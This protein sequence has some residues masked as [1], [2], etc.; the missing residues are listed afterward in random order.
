MQSK[1]LMS[2][3]MNSLDLSCV[4]SVFVNVVTEVNLNQLAILLC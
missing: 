3:A 2:R 1:N 4:G